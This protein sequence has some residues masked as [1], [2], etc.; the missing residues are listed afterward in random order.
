MI[1]I[2]IITAVWKR[3]KLT[4]LFLQHLLE[5]KNILKNRYIIHIVVAGS[6]KYYETLCKKL[7]INYVNAPNNPLSMKFSYASFY[8]KRLTP[9]AVMLLG[10]DDFISKN[11]IPTM[12]KKL[13]ENNNNAVGLKD[14]YIIDSK[15]KELY[16]YDGYFGYRRLQYSRLSTQT[17]GAGRMFSKKTME[18]LNWSLW[19]I[20]KWHKNRG[21]DSDCENKLLNYNIK[22]TLII[23]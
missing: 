15:Q 12:Y 23:S 17:I 18:K 5:I 7:N 20:K 3:Y 1:K 4:E 10:S 9:D 14:F 8:C 16:K 11:L 19:E 13:L 2:C 22:I 6:E 21:L